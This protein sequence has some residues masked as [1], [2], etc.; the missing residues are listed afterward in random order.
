MGD[1]LLTPPV[2]ADTW[3]I[4]SRVLGDADGLFDGSQQPRAALSPQGRPKALGLADEQP[5][6]HVG[7]LLHTLT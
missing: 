6:H 4:P 2:P 1:S 3:A 5:Y 7:V